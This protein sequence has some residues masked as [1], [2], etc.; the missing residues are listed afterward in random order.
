MGKTADIIAFP[1]L[2]VI[3]PLRFDVSAGAQQDYDDFT[4]ALHAAGRLNKRT[5]ALCEQIALVR[6][7]QEASLK[8]KKPI[9]SRDFITMELLIKRLGLDEADQTPVGA[10]KPSN[11]FSHAGFAA[12]RRASAAD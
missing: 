1:A 10:A 9:A 11:R 3:P 7:K 4:R 5:L 6:D 8:K 2:S 12:R